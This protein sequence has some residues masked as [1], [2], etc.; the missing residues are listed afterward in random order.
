MNHYGLTILTLLLSYGSILVTSDYCSKHDCSP[1]TY[2]VKYTSLKE[3]L[4]D[5]ALEESELENKCFQ[6]TWLGA[7]NDKTNTT[8][9]CDI[10][11]DTEH[12]PCFEPIVW[13]NGTYKFN[14]P[15][16]SDLRTKCL[17]GQTVQNTVG[18]SSNFTPICHQHSGKF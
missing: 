8:T 9:A 12:V 5:E 16:L 6:Y 15:N 10:S 11:P 3:A 7:V 14:E 2:Q 4:N 1:K 13:T 18:K 17:Q